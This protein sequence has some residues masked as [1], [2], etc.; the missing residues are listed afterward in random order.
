MRN[1]AHSI[2]RK[3]ISDIQRAKKEGV[4]TT[5][6]GNNAQHVRDSY[7]A[8]VMKCLRQAVSQREG[9]SSGAVKSTPTHST[10]PARFLYP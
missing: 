4:Q 2:T 5:M 6:Y 8:T 1:L 9:V 7:F 3:Q 10:V